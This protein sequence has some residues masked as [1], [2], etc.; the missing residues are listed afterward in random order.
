MTIERPVVSV[1]PAVRNLAIFKLSD[2][3]TVKLTR[4]D[5]TTLTVPFEPDQVLDQKI[6]AK[7]T[8]IKQGLRYMKLHPLNGSPYDATYRSIQHGIAEQK[9]QIAHWKS[10]KDRVRPYL[11]R[12]V[13]ANYVS[14]DFDAGFWRG[15]VTVVHS[16][17]VGNSA[18][19]PLRQ[20]ASIGDI[21]PVD[22]VKWPVVVY[23]EAPPA[24]VLHESAS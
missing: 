15:S 23:L 12:A 8:N 4:A 18:N 6:Q 20:Y 19:D 2:V 9:A 3:E 11:V 13:A 1:R 21:K 7:T 24:R 10:L 17:I 14:Q 16:S 5:C 22:M